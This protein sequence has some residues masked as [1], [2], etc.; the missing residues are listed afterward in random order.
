MLFCSHVEDDKYGISA[1]LIVILDPQL[2]LLHLTARIPINL[3][4]YHY[5]IIHM[6]LVTSKCMQLVAKNELITSISLG[7]FPDPKQ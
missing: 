7:N 2:Y 6:L 3:S 5:F 4:L 1:L